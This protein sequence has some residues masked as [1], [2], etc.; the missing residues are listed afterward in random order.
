LKA[1]VSSGYSAEMVDDKKAIGRNITYLLKPYSV[2][3]L[4]ATVRACLD[5]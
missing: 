4:A 3:T 2:N 1:V 5:S